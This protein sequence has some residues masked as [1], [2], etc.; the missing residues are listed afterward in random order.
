MLVRSP[1]H[2]D[3]DNDGHGDDAGD[4]AED[5]D[6]QQVLHPVPVAPAARGVGGEDDEVEGGVA[7][8]GRDARVRHDHRHPV[9]TDVPVLQGPGER[10]HTVF[11]V[12]SDE[13]RG[14]GQ[15][16]VQQGDVRLVDVAGHHHQQGGAGLGVGGEGQGRDVVW[17]RDDDL[18]RVVVDVAHQHGDAGRACA[19]RLPAVHGQNQQVVLGRHLVVQA[20]LEGQNTLRR[21]EERDVR[22]HGAVEG[23]L[24]RV[25]PGQ[26]VGD[27]A[28][29]V[30]VRVLG[31]DLAHRRAHRRVLGHAHLVVVPLE[32][33][34]DVVDV[35]HR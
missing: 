26:G 7:G 13:G 11:A 24:L 31:A 25:G 14:P 4:A 10:Q 15:V 5:D 3:G 9:A 29:V 35:L 22:V 33:R 30:A 12:E 2:H 6:D 18:R 17:V 27:A 23:E 34:A 32:D 19:R 28:V 20:P 1:D 8:L 21:D 16:V